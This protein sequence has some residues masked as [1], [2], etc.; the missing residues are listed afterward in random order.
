MRHPAV[1]RGAERLHVEVDGCGGI[2][3]DEVRC[4]EGLDF[5]LV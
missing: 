3:H 2:I 5:W 4:D 1:L